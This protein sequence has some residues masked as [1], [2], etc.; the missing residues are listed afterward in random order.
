ML[1]PGIPGLPQLVAAALGGLAL[2]I[3]LV[4][5]L[6]GNLVGVL[7][8]VCGTALLLWSLLKPRA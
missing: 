7:I 8:I 3:G 1:R 2:A 5:L 4:A 6:N